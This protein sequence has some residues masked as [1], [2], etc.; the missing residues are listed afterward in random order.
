M[1]ETPTATAATADVAPGRS[2][3]HA[4]RNLDR[5]PLTVV[6]I[7]ALILFTV[8]G[9]GGP[10]FGQ[11]VFA[12]TDELVT[13]APYVG[14]G[15]A[16]AP[17]R[18]DS[19]DDTWASGIPSTL[20]FAD[21]LGMGEFASWNPYVSAGS[22]LGGTPT[23]ALL[24]PVTVPFYLLP[25]WLA[26]AFVKLL[27]IV[28]AVLGCHLF[29]RRLGLGR[30][31]A[32]TGG[33][34]FVT[35]AFMVAWTN[36]PQTRVAAVVPFLFWAVER[37][38]T[39]R[40]PADVA[41]IA[42][43]VAAM[44][45]GGFPAVAGYALL[46]A[47][48]WFVVR[49]VAEHRGTPTRTLGTL[50]AGAAGVVGGVALSAAQLV[51]FTLFMQ[52]AFVEGRSQTPQ[53]HLAAESLVTS[54]APWALGGVSQDGAPRWF[55]EQ[56]FVESLSYMGA[57]AL[58]LAIVA[59]ASVRAARDVLPRGVWSLLV[60]L[61]ASGIVVVW[62]GGVPLALLQQLPVLF[63]DNFVGRARSVL[64]FFGAV[65]AAVGLEVLL[66][67]RRSLTAEPRTGIVS[68]TFAVIVWAGAAMVGL[69]VWRQAR[70]AAEAADLAASDGVDRV[71]H[72]DGQ[73]SLGLA[74]VVAAVICVAALR[75]EPT[76][77]TRRTVVSTT[78]V[79]VLFALITAQA[80][81]L[82][83]PYWPRVDRDTFYPQT[84]THKFLT[85]SLDRE[86]FA[87]TWESMVMGADAAQRIRAL[88]GHSFVDARLGQLVRT[89]PGTEGLYPTY[90]TFPPISE[91]ATAPALDRLGTRY[92]VTAPQS[93]VFGQLR[94]ASIDG[95]LATLRPGEPVEVELPGS[96]PLRG[97]GVLPVAA[98]PQRDATLQITLRNPAGQVV[99]E[100]ERNL[101]GATE[102]V[103]F[104]VA[105]AGEEVRQDQDLVA[106]LVLQAD[107]PM[108]VRGAAGAPALPVVG[109]ADDG[110]RLVFAD[111][112]VVYERLTALPRI[113]WAPRSVIEPDAARRLEAL[114]TGAVPPDVVVLDAPS[115]PSSGAD[116][117]VSVVEDG[118]DSIEVQVDARGAG[119]LVVADALQTGWSATLDGE[120]VPLVAA[121]HAGVAVAVPVGA[122]EIQLSY[123]AP[124]A[125]VGAGTSIA[126]VVVLV[127]LLGTGLRR[128]PS[129][130]ART[131]D[132]VGE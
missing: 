15:Y 116:A 32:L 30:A 130:P 61:V 129:V 103:P 131:H 28:V 96:G 121:D 80:L 14:A 117:T 87:G 12:G 100:N 40:R 126:A 81:T 39:R 118:T 110:L 51:P 132:Q 119:H 65:L 95:S 53:D 106:T 78:A 41:L 9:I 63:S 56:N 47:G 58:V 123:R 125:G 120:P 48:V 107:R 55:L 77:G 73:M 6:A 18:N 1:T 94:E 5:D 127:G 104:L 105:L 29:L 2:A 25:G 44:L 4:A 35:S 99:A 45:V 79:L 115:T 89:V 21:A 34:V 82:V 68:V 57:A 111:S 36:W 10:L 38:V 101:A 86:R 109:A 17:V 16:T 64:G 42:L 67:S 59:V 83:R 85:A 122:H 88:T 11:G 31:A 102:D 49:V 128:R 62:F 75:G 91:A 70:L 69:V 19:V 114:G 33:L 52:S 74:F 108:T 84:T 113:R 7:A 124:G 72:L 22:P 24:H 97:A 3:R 98:D 26:P 13:N 23:N 112:G 90:V 46:T 66:R 92:F 50:A 60:G 71:S 8:L 54:I 43:P 76:A 27:E 20:L 93:P 37:L